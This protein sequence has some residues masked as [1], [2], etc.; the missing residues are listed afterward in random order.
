MRLAAA[1]ALMLA[2][3]ATHHAPPH[4]AMPPHGFVQ[5]GIASWY[6]PKFQGRLTASGERFDMHKL[7]AAHRTLPLGTRVRVI[8]LENGRS[9]VVRI[10]DRGPFVK[11]R[12]IDLSYEAARRLGFVQQ[13]TARVRIVAPGAA[14]SARASGTPGKAYVQLGAFRQREGALALL[15]RFAHLGP[16]ALAHDPTLDVWRVRIG[17]VSEKEARRLQRRLMQEGVGALIV[18]E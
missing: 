16:I 3:C 8:N 10:N 11:N 15:Q 13:G 9:V 14:A 5:E 2:A 17:P 18:H 4:A 1:L 7:T 12:I 6:G